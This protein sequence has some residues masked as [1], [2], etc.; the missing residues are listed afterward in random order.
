M[1]NKPTLVQVGQALTIDALRQVA[2][3]RAR[4]PNEIPKLYDTDF[5]LYR[6]IIN[7]EKL[8]RCKTYKDVIDKAEK[9]LRNHLCKFHELARTVSLF[10]VAGVIS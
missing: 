10:H 6:W 3:L 7:A 5:N 1:T 4:F 2:A 8:H 9:C